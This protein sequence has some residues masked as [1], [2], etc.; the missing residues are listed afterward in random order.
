[1]RH[2]DNQKKALFLAELA[3]GGSVQRTSLASGIGRSVAYAWREDDADLLQYFCSVH[4]L[5]TARA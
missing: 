3:D 5:F 4:G 1:M 2:S